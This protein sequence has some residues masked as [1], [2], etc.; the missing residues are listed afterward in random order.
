MAPSA[1]RAIMEQAIVKIE[2]NP[3]RGIFYD[4]RSFL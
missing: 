4:I 1:I 3:E 2:Q